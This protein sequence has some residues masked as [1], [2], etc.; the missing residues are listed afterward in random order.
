MDTGEW[1]WWMLLP[2]AFAVAFGF[3]CGYICG[4]RRGTKDEKT[5]AMMREITQPPTG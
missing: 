1:S 5:A 4:W 2:A 3:Y